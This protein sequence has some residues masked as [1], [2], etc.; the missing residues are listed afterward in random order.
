MPASRDCLA[1]DYYGVPAVET[2][3]H[4]GHLDAAWRLQP[5]RVGD[6]RE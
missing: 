2:D 5:V 1:S 6:A 3:P 4:V